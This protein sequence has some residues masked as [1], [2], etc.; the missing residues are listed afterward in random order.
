M[1]KLNKI[2][3][4][5]VRKVSVEAFQDLNYRSHYS[6]NNSYYGELVNIQPNRYVA[7]VEI[8]I[9]M[10][11]P[12]DSH[13]IH[14]LQ[15]GGLDY[16]AKMGFDV[17]KFRYIMNEGFIRLPILLKHP[18]P[19]IAKMAWILSKYFA[20]RKDIMPEQIIE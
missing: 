9:D 15:V 19:E 10:I 20:Q 7:N 1:E 16:V 12:E 2:P 8:S 5:S 17:E 11:S 4:N 3:R 6:L 14:E 13:F 18:D